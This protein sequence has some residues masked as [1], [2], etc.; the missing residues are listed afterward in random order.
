MIQLSS[1]LN[2][3]KSNIIYINRTAY[4]FSSLDKRKKQ[5]VLG[6]RSDLE[7]YEALKNGKIN[8]PKPDIVLKCSCKKSNCLKLYC[9]CF[10]KQQHCTK[11]C[12]CNCCYNIPEKEEYRQLFYKDIVEKNPNALKSKITN[13]DQQTNLIHNRGCNCKKTGCVKKYCEC[14]SAGTKCTNLCRCIGCKNSS[15][16]HSNKDLLQY[17]EKV[18]RKRKRRVT[19][20]IAKVRQ[21]IKEETTK[22]I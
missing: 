6:K 21:K 10:A 17:H 1:D 14:Y 4:P 19:G 5:V 12:Q 11:E 15:E 18:L 22:L 3:V 8:F 13:I 2:L 16:D 9:E 20:V 7:V